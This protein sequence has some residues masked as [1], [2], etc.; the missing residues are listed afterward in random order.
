MNRTEKIL[1]ILKNTDMYVSGKVIA[2]NLDIS[3][4]A[5]SRLIEKLRE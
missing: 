5:V 1:G 3:K 2:H 4:S